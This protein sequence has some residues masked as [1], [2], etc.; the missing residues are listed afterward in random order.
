MDIADKEN[1]SG[2]V[3]SVGG[4]IPNNL[5]LSLSKNGLKILGTS[6]ENIDRAEDRSKFSQLLDNLGIE[7]PEWAK[8]ESVE[9]A[10][11]FAREI[12]YPVLVR[13]SYV[14]SG[15]A[16]N[17]A[18]SDQELEDY[19]EEA[20]DVSRE[21]PVVISK[22][23]TDAK[24]VEVDGVCDGENVFL[25]AIIE[26]IEN[27]GVHSGD[28]TMVIPTVNVEENVK[29]EIRRIS[30]EIARNLMI[31]GPFNL[32]FLVKN[33]KVYV[34]ECNLRSSR[35]MPF[36]S[37]ITG[38]NFMDVAASVFLDEKI[39]DDEAVPRSYGIKSPQFSFMRLEGAD[40]VTGVDMVS[41]G[42]V[43]CFGSTFEDALLKSL[44]ASGVRLPKS[45]DSILISIGGQKT[46]AVEI[47]K[48]LSNKGYKIFAT[49]HTAEALRKGGVICENIYK[50]S[51][52]KKPNVLDALV[53]R[54]IKFV[55]NRPSPDIMD[56]SSLT[57]GYLIRR[58]AVE[59]G[60]PIVTNIEL[61]KSFAES[62]EKNGETKLLI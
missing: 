31:K 40:P 55:I 24:E 41:T 23:V 18:H 19:L 48:T 36:V 5:A 33:S 51:E 29:D 60:I 45:G 21:H 11:L 14:I 43:A 56:Q 58:K 37:K 4:Q 52:G 28:A 16:M 3:V 47:A 7:Q 49:E 54:E 59:F 9:K 20:V 44:I 2:V 6:S 1:P 27:A 35:S 39:S 32:Q 13:P 17:I 34:I 15:S 50:I 57:D 61:A 30:G 10:V 62:L 38:I 12:G 22:F 8:L 46:E 42:E 53:N 26:H 25:G